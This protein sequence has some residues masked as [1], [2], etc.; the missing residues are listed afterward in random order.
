MYYSYIK[1]VIYIISFCL[2]ANCKKT[3]ID[4]TEKQ[5]FSDLYISKARERQRCTYLFAV[6]NSWTI[7][8]TKY[9]GEILASKNIDIKIFLSYYPSAPLELY[10]KN[11]DDNKRIF[12][13]HKWNKETGWD[14]D[15]VILYS[16]EEMAKAYSYDIITLQQQSFNAGVYSTIKPYLGKIIKW[17]QINCSTIPV[18]FY[19]ITWAYPDFTINKNFS[20]YDFNSNFMYESIIATWKKIRKNNKIDLY[21]NT[22]DIIKKARELNLPDIDTNDGTHLSLTGEYIA[23]LLWARTFMESFYMMEKE[24][25]IFSLESTF[26]P[27]GISMENKK[28]ILE[29]LNHSL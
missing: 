14:R 19:H 6:G 1:Y 7:N 27:E 2:F 23:S 29:L 13:F 9:L 15:N 24:E 17:Y 10:Y 11:T 28:K 5:N 8:A 3:E 16:F 18:L 20:V 22:A 25:M 12:E 21:I 26:C 4:L